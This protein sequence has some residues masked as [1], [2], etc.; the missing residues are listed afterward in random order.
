MPSYPH[1][2]ALAAAFSDPLAPAPL[3]AV[4][5]GSSPLPKSTPLSSLGNVDEYE[6][7]TVSRG[8]VE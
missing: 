6:V 8:G 3:A 2:Q 7:W 1:R 5:G 4:L